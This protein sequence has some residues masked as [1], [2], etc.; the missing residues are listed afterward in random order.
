[1]VL[2]ANDRRTSCP[3]HDEFRG[4]RSD[5]VRQVRANKKGPG[6]VDKIVREYDA[7]NKESKMIQILGTVA[8]LRV[9]QCK[10]EDVTHSAADGVRCGSLN[11]N[12]ALFSYT[13]AFGD[14]PRN[15]EPWSSDGCSL[16]KVRLKEIRGKDGLDCSLTV[17]TSDRVINK[18]QL[19]L[20]P[21]WT[22]RT[23]DMSLCHYFLLGTLKFKVCCR[24]SISLQELQ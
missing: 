18:C 11:I 7:H 21:S 24:N 23:P 20:G 1:M 16:W 5:Y 17:F 13:R 4:P 2:K 8:S 6:R 9:D 10:C 14:G 19:G 15:F 3:C 12:V 22:P